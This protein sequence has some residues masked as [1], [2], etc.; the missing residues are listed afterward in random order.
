MSKDIHQLKKKKY[1][2]IITAWPCWGALPQLCAS[3]HGLLFT[4][5]SWTAKAGEGFNPH[6]PGKVLQSLPLGWAE[7][8]TLQPSP[9][10]V[11]DFA[12]DSRAGADSDSNKPFMQ[13]AGKQKQ[14]HPVAASSCRTHLTHSGCSL[15]PAVS[16]SEV[17]WFTYSSC[18]LFVKFNESPAM[19]GYKEFPG[20][21][22]WFFT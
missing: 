20:S 19:W 12:A 7:T 8:E 3:C 6:C 18:F 11:V 9:L 5:Q 14:S 22:Q 2:Y 16:N 15:T 1:I 17:S 21:T 13:A 4:V 10:G